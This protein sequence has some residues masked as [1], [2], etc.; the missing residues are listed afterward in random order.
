[1]IQQPKEVPQGLPEMLID[2]EWWE[3]EIDDTILDLNDEMEF[4]EFTLK[5]QGAECAPVTGLMCVAGQAGNGKTL[6]I[7]MLMSVYLGA[8]IDGIELIWEREHPRVMYIDTEMEKGN[9]QLVVARVSRMTGMSIDELSERMIV[10]RL[11]EEENTVDRWRKILKAVC[12]FKPDVVFLDGV[13]DIVEDFND[14][15][16]SNII[17]RKLMKV[18]D[19]LNIAMWTVMHQNPGST[20]LV[21][22][23]GS[24]MMRKSTMVL[25]NTKVIDDEV[26]PVV[27]FELKNQKVR[28]GDMTPI[29][30]HYEPFDLPN[31]HKSVFPVMGMRTF[32]DVTPKAEERDI[33]KMDIDER[34]EFF[35]YTITKNEGM[36]TRDIE[37]AVRTEY[38]V[39]SGIARAFLVDCE[40]QGVI[41]VKQVGKAKMYMLS[42]SANQTSFDNG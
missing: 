27:H 36:C 16:E 14:N 2:D 26:G 28:S 35:F 21:G 30:Y 5:M 15:K 38:G 33:M 22:H 12:V 41:V 19:K 24:F 10:Q 20:K 17:I 11:R 18:A 4:P 37:A 23:A 32:V 6:T 29:V 7:S 34:R 13:I 42:D 1:M 40:K 9:T 39:G 31:G 3:A 25:S 8:Q